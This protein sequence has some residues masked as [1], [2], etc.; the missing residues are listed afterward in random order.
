M[1]AMT[2]SETAL[3]LVERLRRG[4]TSA[5][6]VMRFYLR[7]IEEREKDVRAFAH[8]APEAAIG[9][10]EKA[11]AAKASG[12][13]LGPLHGLPVAVKDII[14]TADMPTEFGGEIFAGRRPPRDATI[15]SRLRSA[16]AIVV[17]K[18]VTSQYALFVPGP[19]R[20]PH[21]LEHTPGGSSSGSA[22]AVAAGF[23]PVALGTQTN[24]SVV[25][26]ASYCGVVGFK[27]SLGLLPRTGVLR[28]APLMDH[29]GVFAQTVADAAMV[30]DAIGGEDAED[31]FSRPMPG[32]LLA[33]AQGEGPPLRL[34]FTLGPFEDRADPATREALAAFLTSLPFKAEAVALGPEFATAEATMW[35]L[36]CAGVAESMGPDI[37]RARDRIPERVLG[38][39]AEGRAL[40]AVRLMEAWT[41]RD[42]LRATAAK[43]IAPYDALLTFA[44][45]GPAP[46]ASQ[47]T[48]DPIF[49]TLW[50]LIGAPA[51]SLPLMRAAN[52]LPIGVQA[53]G[54]PGR[55]LDLARAAAWLMRV[56]A[57]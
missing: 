3:D 20:N 7:R 11:D 12:L 8:L 30:V 15:V 47:G 45:S 29:P 48:G 19:T 33:A 39:V 53:V 26:P 31:A 42:A 23:V 4:E 10:A 44:S 5:V 41:R 46:L 50:S 43:L 1:N 37:D 32:S 2:R 28:H 17:G 54:A 22:A 16:G 13:A 27:P 25:R 57:R 55:D 38:I 52:G 36:M 6:D 40:S 9:A 21:D 24:G 34:A 51:M 18:A 56:S 35:D 49:A 14:D